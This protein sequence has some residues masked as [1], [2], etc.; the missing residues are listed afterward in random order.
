[1]A[2]NVRRR[3]VLQMLGGAGVMSVPVGMWWYQARAHRKETQ[4]AHSN[5]PLSL[6]QDTYDYLISEKCQAGDVILFDRRCERC[7]ASPW[8]ALACLAAKNLLGG[9]CQYDHCGIVVPGYIKT[10]ADRFDPTNLLLLEATPS[11]VVAFP[12]KQ[13]LEQ[14]ASHSILLLQV[15]S[16]GERRR[17]G[18]DNASDAVER[19]LQ[20]TQR[21]LTSFRDQWLRASEKQ[22]YHYFHSTV[23]IGGAVAYAL[24]LQDLIDG[25]VSPAAL[26]VLSGLQKAGIAMN[27]NDRESRQTQVAD[28]LKDYRLTDTNV[29]RLR[30][31]YRFLP[32]IT[33]KQGNTQF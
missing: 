32:P 2:A 12:L 16:P 24:G 33:L 28:F 29:V 3:V 26:L 8:A 4:L 15:C 14:S 22:G 21:E 30:P 18:E 17:D 31:G 13:R 20:F 19:T 10:K 5:K 25:P 11:G 7:V 6:T 27:I 23:T 9:P 1:M